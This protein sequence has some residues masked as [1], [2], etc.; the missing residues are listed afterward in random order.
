MVERQ[1]NICRLSGDV[2]IEAVPEL[3]EKI[4]PLIR[5]GVDTLDCAAVKNVDSS[6]LGLLLACKREA[7]ADQTRMKLTGLPPS[8]LSLAS[9]Y[10]V[11]DQ[12]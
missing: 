8:L 4:K 11:A 2:T 6:A 7:L 1:D 5:S 12:L 10:G 9:L 3:L